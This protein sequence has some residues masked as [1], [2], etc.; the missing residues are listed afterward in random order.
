MNPESG[1][2][3]RCGAEVR[4]CPHG[5]EHFSTE[6]EA[7]QNWSTNYERENTEAS[8]SLRKAPKAKPKLSYL[9]K[10]DG[11]ASQTVKTVFENCPDTHEVIIRVFT[12]PDEDSS[13]K[14]GKCQDK[15]GEYWNENFGTVPGSFVFPLKMFNKEI[16]LE[17]AAG[18]VQELL[19]EEYFDAP[20][21]THP[22][23]IVAQV[24]KA[25]LSTPKH[26]A[27][28][29][30]EFDQQEFY[31]DSLPAEAKSFFN[32]KLLDRAYGSKIDLPDMV[33]NRNSSADDVIG[34]KTAPE[35]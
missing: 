29:D 6:G 19:G 3:G 17:L 27:T 35:E 23:W 20:D 1:K 22:G 31:G 25:D 21:Y 26:V 34:F 28:Y 8:D 9:E 4:D 2:A 7:V 30:I 10:A 13:L 18:A 15:E 33:W 5:G 11:G 24:P 16:S 12:H 14:E 32:P